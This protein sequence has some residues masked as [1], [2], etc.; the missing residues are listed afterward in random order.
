[1]PL[2]SFSFNIEGNKQDVSYVLDCV[3]TSVPWVS[4]IVIEITYVMGFAKDFTMELN[5]NLLHNIFSIGVTP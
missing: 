1:M 5:G 3:L 4:A 2:R